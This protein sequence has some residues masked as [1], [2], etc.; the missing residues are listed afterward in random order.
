MKCSKNNNIDDEDLDIGK[1]Q[2]N[3]ENFNSNLKY[4]M[5]NGPPTLFDDTLTDNPTSHSYS[6]NLS[7]G[8]NF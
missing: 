6:V 7:S 1:N 4:S 2:L 3:D 8:K 5:K